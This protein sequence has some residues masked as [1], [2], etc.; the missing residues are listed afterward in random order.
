MGERRIGNIEGG[1]CA[2]ELVFAADV[3]LETRLLRFQ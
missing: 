1:E 3:L 2:S